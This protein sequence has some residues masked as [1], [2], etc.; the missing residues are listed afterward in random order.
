MALAIVMLLPIQALAQ[1]STA[2]L[3]VVLPSASCASLADFDLAAIGGEG[4]VITDASV[5]TSDGISVCN[6]TGT[7]APKINFQV[8]LPTETWTQRYLQVGCGGLCGSITLTSGAS[9]GCS[10]LAAGGFVMAATDMGHTDQ[11]GAWGKDEQQRADFAYR[12]QHVTALAAKALIV[13]F[14]GQDPAYSYFNGCSDGGR[15]ALMEAMRFP[16]DFDGIVAGAPAMLFQ[17]QNTLH[18]GWLASSN[19]DDNGEVILTSD[20]LPILHAAVV[21]ACDELDG[22][23]DGLVSQPALCRFDP[24]TLIGNGLTAEE[25]QVASRVYAGPADATTGAPLVAGSALYGSELNWQGVFVADDADSTL[26]SE[27]IVDPVLRY[28]AFETANPDYE[29]SDL[30]FTE[31]TLGALMARHPLFD[32]VNTNLTPFEQSG[33]KLILWHGLADPHISPANTVTLHEG[34]LEA[35]GADTVQAFERLYLLPGVSHCGGGEG[36]SALDL[37]TPM[38]A[39]VE[40]GIPPEGIMVSSSDETSSFGSPDGSVGGD[41]AHHPTLANLNYPA[42]P[43]MTRPVYPYPYTAQWTGNGDYT[44]GSSWI[45]GVEVP[46]VRPNDWPGRAMFFTDYEFATD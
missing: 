5:S 7:M 46:I 28:L 11:T 25:A 21:A 32:A 33:G 22:L 17:V 12:A 13:T 16:D 41:N 24:T 26:F 43:D 3:G 27:M 10:I 35:M 2:D 23:K 20:K 19:Y 39:W 9:S 45:K 29:L 4:S 34:L 38:M 31:A 37:L 1:D 18:H 36:P 44:D 30:P 8:L 42:L 14:Y 40:N 15:E 6:V